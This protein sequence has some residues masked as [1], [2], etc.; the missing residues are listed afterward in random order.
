MLDLPIANR[1][2]HSEVPS[3]QQ[4]QEDQETSQQGQSETGDDPGAGV[5]P[6]GDG[7]VPDPG[8]RLQRHIDR[9]WLWE[10]LQ[11]DPPLRSDSGV[12]DLWT[13]RWCHGE[14]AFHP[15]ESGSH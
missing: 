5:V 10:Y 15:G 7:R 14:E 1:L 9:S 2:Q 3:L 8:V 4:A 6:S 11:L 12:D 13:D